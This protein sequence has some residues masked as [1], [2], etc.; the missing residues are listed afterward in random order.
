MTKTL[1]TG[2]IDL[3]TA[4]YRIARRENHKLTTV[5][6]DEADAAWRTLCKIAPSA[7]LIL[8]GDGLV[9]KPGLVQFE[10]FADKYWKF[11]SVLR[12]PPNDNWRLTGEIERYPSYEV[13]DEHGVKHYGARL[14]FHESEI[15]AAWWE[16][17]EPVRRQSI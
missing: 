3:D 16:S 10:G 8:T 17:M 1:P 5:Y 13:L 2:Y 15:D 7:A 11:A 6:R 14:V 12:Y 9:R 4:I